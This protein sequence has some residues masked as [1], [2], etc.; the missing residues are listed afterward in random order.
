MPFTIDDL[1]HT[2][3]QTEQQLLK[4]TDGVT[5]LADGQIRVR[6]EVGSLS[7]WA[8][9]RA[10]VEAQAA[11]T[12]LLQR[13]GYR[14]L[15]QPGPLPVDGE[16]DVAVPLIDAQGQRYWA[17]V[18]AKARLRRGDVQAW[19]RRLRDPRFLS[20]LQA[21]GV[22]APF[23]AYTFGLRVYPDALKRAQE[24]GIGI[25]DPEGERLEPKPHSGSADG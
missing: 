13:K 5:R 1:T 18:E 16:V 23:L 4:L 7:E 24:L 19:E 3:A 10:E 15:G 2:Q 11:L 21:E 9:A 17:L 22:T 8:G 25:L 20:R 14:L 6:R 12:E